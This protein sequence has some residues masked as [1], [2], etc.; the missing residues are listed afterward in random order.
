[1]SGV[2]DEEVIARMRA[3]IQQLQKVMSLAHDPRM[4]AALKDVIESGEA[5]IRKLDAEAEAGPGHD[6][7]ETP[8][9]I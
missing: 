2:M 1:M 6:Q 8:G 3:R 7:G 9:S 5:D 4:I